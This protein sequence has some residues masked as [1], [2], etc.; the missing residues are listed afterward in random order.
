[1]VV[2]HGSGSSRA[3]VVSQTVLKALVGIG[4]VLVLLLLVLGGAA[5]SRGVSITKSRV[6][7]R[8]NRLLASEIERMRNRL[9]GLHDT[10]STFSQRAQEL[11]LLAGLTPTEVSAM[12]ELCR[13]LR[14]TGLTVLVIEHVLRAIMA[15]SDRVVVLD[16]GER[17]AEGP[18]AVVS[19]DARV[20][21]AYLGASGG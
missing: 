6:L 9:S 3:V 20:V 1:M 10:L 17:I 16:H 21:A 18:P 2:P 14:A 13:R 19:R 5:L 11:R 8:E 12:I 7:E 4:S 15:L